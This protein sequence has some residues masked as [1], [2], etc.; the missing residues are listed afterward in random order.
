MGKFRL[1]AA[2]LVI[3]MLAALAGCKSE[4][5]SDGDKPG[6]SIGK[7]EVEIP[8]N[9]LVDWIKTG[10]IYFEYTEKTVQPDGEA[11][12]SSSGYF[13]MDGDSLVMQSESGNGT[14]RVLITGGRT[15]MIQV[16]NE[17]MVS[18]DS[19]A[20][21]LA[22]LESFPTDRS[23]EMTNSGKEE[24]EGEKT[25]FADYTI[26]R[27]TFRF[28]FSDDSVIAW[29]TGIMTEGGEALSVVTPIQAS[30]TVP[31]GIFDVPDYGAL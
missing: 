15:Y 8:E 13:A 1:A 19:A 20:R 5:S 30:G 12:A 24:F 9:T 7:K 6:F 21:D 25:V 2:L 22:A 26:G 31:A 4:S 16:S 29:Q 27:K 23:V 10:A 3:A 17:S 14:M 28:W 18:A 11:L